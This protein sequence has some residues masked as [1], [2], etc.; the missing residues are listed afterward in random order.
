MQSQVGVDV[1]KVLFKDS[2]LADSILGKGNT[3][4]QLWW[5][6]LHDSRL[7]ENILINESERKYFIDE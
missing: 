6:A 7:K 5:W 3:H 4:I 1:V 2:I